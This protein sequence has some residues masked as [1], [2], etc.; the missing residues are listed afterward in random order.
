M[1]QSFCSESSENPQHHPKD[2]REHIQQPRSSTED[3]PSCNC[4]KRYFVIA[5]C[6]SRA[7]PTQAQARTCSSVERV[8]GECLQ[9]KVHQPMESVQPETQQQYQRKRSDEHIGY[10]SHDPSDFKHGSA[11]AGKI[12]LL[13]TPSV[14]VY[15]AGLRTTRHSRR[16]GRLWWRRWR[17]WRRRRRP[18]PAHTRR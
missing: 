17:R 6:A 2:N 15:R 14:Y 7:P 1:L 4:R 12:Q 9:Q 10:Q 3:E 13:V 11:Q 16:A 5:R 18:A 8:N